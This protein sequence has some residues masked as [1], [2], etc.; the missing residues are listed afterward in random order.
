MRSGFK[1]RSTAAAER[2]LLPAS[3]YLPKQDLQ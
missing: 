2:I 3:V 1:A